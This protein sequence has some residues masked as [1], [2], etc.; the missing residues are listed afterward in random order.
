MLSLLRVK[1]FW[2]TEKNAVPYKWNGSAQVMTTF[3]LDQEP[4]QKKQESDNF[5][6]G[7]IF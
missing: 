1:K 2:E 4:S 3:F 5:Q 7:F 6:L